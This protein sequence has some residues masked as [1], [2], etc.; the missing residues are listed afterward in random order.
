MCIC[1][2]TYRHRHLP[3]GE[4][5]KGA[6]KGRQPPGSHLGVLHFLL[7]KKRLSMVSVGSHVPRGPV[8]SYLLGGQS[9][10]TLPRLADGSGG[11]VGQ[12]CVST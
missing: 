10:L 3:L 1:T 6:A 9:S 8:L 2:H 12:L 5:D 7:L 11:R 4:L